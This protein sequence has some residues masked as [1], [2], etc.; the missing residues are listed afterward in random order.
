MHMSARYQP[1]FREEED[2]VEE[3]LQTNKDSRPRIAV[4]S[5]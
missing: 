5:D 1:T 3:I 2:V 4:S